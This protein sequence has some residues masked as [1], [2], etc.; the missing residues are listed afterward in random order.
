MISMSKKKQ[1]QDMLILPPFKELGISIGQESK[2]IVPKEISDIFSELS[3]PEGLSFNEGD[4]EQNAE[5][6]VAADADKNAIKEWLKEEKPDKAVI[7]LIN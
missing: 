5:L 1:F 4:D 7:K 3:L 6:I 2:K